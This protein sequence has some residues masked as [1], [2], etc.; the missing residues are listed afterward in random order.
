MDESGVEILRGYECNGLYVTDKNEYTSKK[1]SSIFVAQFKP[2]SLYDHIHQV[3]GHSG[4]KAIKWHRENSLNAKYTDRDESKDRG[5]C[6]GCVYG[7]LSPTNTDQY[8]EHREMPLIPGQC[9]SLDAYTHTSMSTRGRK[10]CD[11]YTDLGTRRIYPV[12]TKNRSAQELCQQSRLLFLQHPDWTTNSSREQVRFIRLDSE[13]NYRSEE[14]LAFTSSIG[15]NL[16]RTPVRDKHANGVAERTVGLISAKT[17]VAM[18]APNPH[19][20]Q[21]YWDFAMA[22]ACDTHSFNYSSVIGTSPYMKITGQPV[23]IKYL[24]PFWSSC[25]VFIPREERNKIGSPRAYKA[26]FV[27]YAN[28][29][30]LFPNCIV[31][32]VTRTG[33]YLKFKDSK[34][35]I[36]DSTINFDVYTNNEEPYD[37]E[38]ENTDHYVPFMQSSEAPAVLQ[39]PNVK[40][41]IPNKNE[42]YVPITPSRTIITPKE[43]IDTPCNEEVS[44]EENINEYH[45][46]YEESDGNPVYWYK[47][48]VKNTEYPLVMCE[49]HHFKKIKIGHDPRVPQNY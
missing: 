43:I 26:Q 13:S 32:P 36:F 11:L 3:T 30:I 41:D 19:A 38:F 22:Y 23:D 25:Y 14:F 12:F 33:H 16:E 31:I 27:G 40:P 5:I 46:P 1:G 48:H 29:S 24:Q 49:I 2:V 15:Y 20:P 8:R 35:V 42:T 4:K 9:F 10:Y 6:K 17:N 7:A 45:P 39:G 34:N 37:R 47:Y 21:S 18:M 28:R 44:F